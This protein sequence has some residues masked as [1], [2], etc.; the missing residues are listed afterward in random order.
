M[1]SNSISI[2][3]MSPLLDRDRRRSRSNNGDINEMEIELEGIYHT[4]AH[5]DHFLASAEI[6]EKT[7]APIYLHDDDRFLWDSLEMQCSYFNIEF[8]PT[9]PPD[10]KIEDE[11]ELVH[12]DGVCLHTPGHTPGSVSFHFD[13]ANLLV[14][15]DTLFN[16]SV[17]RTDLPGGDFK[18]LKSSIQNKIYTLD[19]ATTVITGHG[20]ETSIRKEMTNNMVIRFDS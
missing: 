16:G 4:H 5:F 13:S 20:P 1:P 2:S 17:G 14:A 18:K 8:K 9:P 11:Q 3:L 10:F 19:E 6:K 7:G 15:G 12:C